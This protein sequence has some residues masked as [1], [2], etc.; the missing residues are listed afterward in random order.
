MT[1][2]SYSAGAVDVEEESGKKPEVL[3]ILIIIH[4]EKFQKN[5][6]LIIAHYLVTLCQYILLNKEY[7]QTHISV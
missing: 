5:L 7:I 1:D 6:N 4:F 3:T 2:S